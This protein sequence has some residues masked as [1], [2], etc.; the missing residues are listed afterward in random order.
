MNRSTQ[1]KTQHAIDSVMSHHQREAGRL[2]VM[3]S[4]KDWN[5]ARQNKILP[6]VGGMLEAGI[7]AQHCD[8]DAGRLTLPGDVSASSRYWEKT[9]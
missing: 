3:P 8:G 4:R 6:G 5:I 7:G 9:Y 2:V 1:L